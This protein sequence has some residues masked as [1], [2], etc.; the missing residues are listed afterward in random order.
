MNIVWLG[1][2]FIIQYMYTVQYT[3]KAAGFWYTNG[4]LWD[5][6]VY[7]NYMLKGQSHEIFDS[8]FFSLI[9]PTW[10]NDQRVKIFLHM[11]LYVYTETT[12][13]VTWI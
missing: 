2:Y 3:T 5:I 13:S 10:V 4:P 6:A 1:R 11:V 12:S 9:N 7:Y 8:R